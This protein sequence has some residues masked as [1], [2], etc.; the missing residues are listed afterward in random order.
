LSLVGAFVPRVLWPEKPQKRVGQDFGH[1]YGYLYTNDQSTSI[2]LPFLVEFYANFG[3]R[4]VYLGMFAIGM[5]LAVLQRYLNRPRQG[6]L[7]S[8]AALVLLVPI[9]TN[10]E[11]DFSLIFGG[12][13]LNGAAMYIVYRFLVAKCSRGGDTRMVRRSA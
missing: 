7:R 5:L 6:W 4:G 2:N 8:L 1:R 11:S 12:L 10:I 13:I 3:E 9:I